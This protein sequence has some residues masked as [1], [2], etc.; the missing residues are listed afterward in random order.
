MLVIQSISGPIW[1]LYY[2]LARNGYELSY[3][4]VL[5]FIE[6]SLFAFSRLPAERIPVPLCGPTAVRRLSSWGC[7]FTFGRSQVAVE[8]WVLLSLLDSEGIREDESIVF[9]PCS[10][11]LFPNPSMVTKIKFSYLS[12]RG[13]LNFKLWTSEFELICWSPKI[14][15]R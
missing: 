7:H 10:R 5:R 13:I 15:G 9:R 6:D 8:V 12:F 1:L 14:T 11:P 3:H 2:S 4:G